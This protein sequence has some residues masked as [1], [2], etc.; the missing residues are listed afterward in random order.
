M[1]SWLIRL[2]FALQEHISK[3]TSFILSLICDGCL[4]FLIIS[5]S[6]SVYSWDAEFFRR[7][8]T[9]N[10]VVYNGS[11]DARRC[12]RKLEFFHEGASIVFQVLISPPEAIVEVF[13]FSLLCFVNNFEIG[14]Y[15]QGPGL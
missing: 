5:P 7:A 3:V 10:V 2:L 13:I 12:I 11:K 8:P 6:T 15:L 4:P 14:N 9:V 1:W